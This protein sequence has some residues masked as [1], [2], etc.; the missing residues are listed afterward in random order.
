MFKHG[1]KCSFICSKL[2]RRTYW[3]L[4]G[5]AELKRSMDLTVESN[6][7]LGEIIICWR[8]CWWR[9][10]IN[11]V[12]R[13]R[14]WKCYRMQST[15]NC[16]DSRSKTLLIF[17]ML[18][19]FWKADSIIE[20][21]FIKVILSAIVFH[22]LLCFWPVIIIVT[23]VSKLPLRLFSFDQVLSFI[24]LADE[25]AIPCTLVR[26]EYFRGWNDI[27]LT[28]DQGWIF[29][30]DSLRFDHPYF[31][32][33]MALIASVGSCNWLI[34]REPVWVVHA[35]HCTVYL[36]SPPQNKETYQSI[37]PKLSTQCTSSHHH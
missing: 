6:R 17:C 33:Q 18:E 2:A 15:K 32:I 37:T 36:L 23:R 14:M 22:I 34:K 20:V 26:G 28:K 27:W 24:V 4:L 1:K 11:L 10:A 3:P 31:V 25:L 16:K 7:E 13:W 9:C 8:I 29:P 21:C 5:L 12:V 30:T 19:K 35:A